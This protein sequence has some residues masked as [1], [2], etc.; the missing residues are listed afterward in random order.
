MEKTIKSFSDQVSELPGGKYLRMCYSCGTCVSRCMVQGRIEPSYNPR[1]LM[2]KAILDME[3]EVFADKT[4]WLCSACDLCYSSCPQEIHISEVLLAIRKLAIEAGRTSP[5]QAA[6]V[7]GQTCIACGL[8]ASVCP[9]QAIT[10][11]Q[12]KV[13][14]Q[15]KVIS[16]VDA[17]ACMGCGLCAA[18]C[19][20]ASIGP[21]GAFSNE[22]L[23][24]DLWQW[25][26][27]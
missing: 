14:G 21:A 24:A 9:Y 25:M 12:D 19:R 2:K 4:V 8:C 15:D 1:R 27:P 22:N 26:R 18:H 16:V 10:L 17:D 3:S 11:K 23:M 5:L 20:S 6:T 13:L 7:D